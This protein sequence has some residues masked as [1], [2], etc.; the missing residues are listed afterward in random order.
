MNVRAML[1]R[2][3]SPPTGTIH[4]I[5]TRVARR[6]RRGTAVV[7]VLVVLSI[8]LAMAYGLMRMQAT[9]EQVQHNSVHRGDARQ[10][11]LTGMSIGLRKMHQTGW[12]ITDQPSGSLNTTDSYGVT[13]STGDPNLASGSADYAMY[14]FRVTVLAKGTST[15][16]GTGTTA[17]HQVR[18]VVQLVPRKLSDPPA[19]WADILP[20][21]VFQKRNDNFEI[22]MPVQI[23]GATRIQGDLKINDRYDNWSDAAATYFSDLKT[24]FNQGTDHRTFTGPIF[25]NASR[26]S[27]TVAS[28]LVTR[29]GL[30]ATNMA[31]KTI[32]DWRS[33]SPNLTYALY[34]G[35]ATYNVTTLANDVA[36][37]TTLDANPLTNPL[38]LYYQ[39]GDVRLSSNVTIRGSLATE[40]SSGVTINGTNVTLTPVDLPPLDGTTTPVRLPT[41]ITKAFKQPTNMRST[42]RGLMS[43]DDEFDILADSQDAAMTL[44]GK[45]VAR[46]VYIRE[47]TEW[48][49]RDWRS[50]FNVLNLIPLL[51]PLFPPWAEANYNTKSIPRVILRPDATTVLYHWI[52]R[53][54]P[55]YAIPASDTGLRW[56]IVSWKDNP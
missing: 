18:A 47:R 4:A 14:P 13:Y 2:M 35:G 34:P 12:S 56:D 39:S 8:G 36:A 3:D 23:R 54:V 16:P 10:A 26:Q 51:K 20:Y 7:L 22:H 31:D 46:K 1:R 24:L 40:G 15:N 6:Q 28:W 55:L 11:A 33:L 17:T 48:D 27:S 49:A 25:W 50:I 21:S 45:L 5:A 32:S 53:G 19:D 9:A 41:V 29:L 43:V 52:T 44:E 37:G 38:G 30:T 42:V